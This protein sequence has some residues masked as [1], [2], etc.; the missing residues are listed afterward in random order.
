MDTRTI[1]NQDEK[2]STLHIDLDTSY[3]V[4][5]QVGQ[6][7]WNNKDNIFV[8]ALGIYS[9]Y[10]LIS[11]KVNRIDVPV[12]E[13]SLYGWYSYDFPAGLKGIA[14]LIDY[15]FPI[16]SKTL[17]Q[18]KLGMTVGILQ[19]SLT[20]GARL[21]E[22]KWRG[23]EDSENKL[24]E[25]DTRPIYD[26]RRYTPLITEEFGDRGMLVFAM[27][28]AFTKLGLNSNYALL[29]S[30]AITNV[31]SGFSHEEDM[32]LPAITRGLIFSGLTFFQKGNLW[33]AAA[34]HVTHELLNAKMGLKN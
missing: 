11:G 19:Y 34:A 26:I 12:T 25:K 31:V 21:L 13:P 15:C 22:R 3:A 16:S 1:E 23:I 2:K 14:T 20:I 7:L 28:T 17:S 9:G 30:V 8:A 6:F 29:G 18:I 27:W 33:P 32:H 4:A 5:R 24:G 10:K